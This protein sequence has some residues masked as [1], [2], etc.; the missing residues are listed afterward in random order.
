MTQNTKAKFIRPS[1]RER[2][3]EIE[4]A[5]GQRRLEIER[6]KHK[7]E[8]QS[9]TRS[10]RAVIGESAD[11]K[12]LIDS[13][14]SLDAAENRGSSSRTRKQ[15]SD[16]S[17]LNVLDVKKRL[18]S[19]GQPI[20]LFGETDSERI[21]RLGQYIRKMEE[22]GDRDDEEG[23]D[24]Y[25]IRAKKQQLDEQDEAD[26]EADDLLDAQQD[27]KDGEASAL[28]AAHAEAAARSQKKGKSAPQE[29]ESADEE[30]KGEGEGEEEGGKEAKW[31]EVKYSEIPGLPAEKVVYKYFRAVVKQWEADLQKREE[32][33][34]RTAKAK[35]EVRTQKQCKDYIR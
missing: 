7:L 11:G 14:L 8:A 19:F 21:S 22:M 9:L 20:T 5:E 28:A 34:K 29:E 26:L 4:L 18:R 27:V 32:S 3:R 23:E 10:K 1:D 2:L 24:E 15:L 35:L 13:T 25:R 12:I 30:D 16:L 6:Q 33:E 17:T 31:L